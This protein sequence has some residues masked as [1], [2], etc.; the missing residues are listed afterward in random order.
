LL[1]DDDALVLSTAQRLLLRAG[2]RVTCASSGAEALELL[3]ADTLDIDVLLS[4]VV[5]PGVS[6]PQLVAARRALGDRRPAVYMSGYTAD[7]LPLPHTP[8]P[9]AEL[10]TK[11]FTSPQLVGAI[12]RAVA[13]ARSAKPAG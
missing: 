8:E 1:I 5:M 2:Y 11:P 13:R 4:D 7:A 10:V 3:A 6:G 9:E 12:E